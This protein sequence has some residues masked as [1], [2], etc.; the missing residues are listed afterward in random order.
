MLGPWVQGGLITETTDG[1]VSYWNNDGWVLGFDSLKNRIP[2]MVYLGS[3]SP[4]NA[5]LTAGVTYQIGNFYFDT[6]N[7]IVYIC[8]TAGDLNTSVWVAIN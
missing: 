3:G 6:T 7:V 5:T 1:T 2:L 8:S 4:S